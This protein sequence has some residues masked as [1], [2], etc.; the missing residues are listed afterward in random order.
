MGSTPPL[1]KMKKALGVGA[2]SYMGLLTTLVPS[3]S[4]YVTRARLAASP[5]ELCLHSGGI[6]RRVG[7][8]G[9]SAIIEAAC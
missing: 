9:S 6:V 1:P 4:S 8:K 2:A 3:F 7:L 5:L